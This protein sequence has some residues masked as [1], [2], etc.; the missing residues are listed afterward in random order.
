[1]KLG[2]LWEIYVPCNYNDGTPVRTRHHR[3]WDE[4][5]RAITGGLTIH[6]P[7]IGQWENAGEVYRDR[8]IP[9][10]LMATAGQMQEIGDLTIQHYEQL[11]VMYYR[12]STA[13]V[14]Q[15]AS[16]KQKS[17]FTRPKRRE[18]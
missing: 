8:V 7:A 1:M 4:K 18:Q 5:V 3:V 6:R 9:V 10:R 17:K 14:I 2:D 11:A 15:E 12:V 16:E 13:C